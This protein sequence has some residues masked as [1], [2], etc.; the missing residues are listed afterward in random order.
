MNYWLVK[1]EPGTYSWDDFVKM[2]RDKWDGV[3]NYQARNNLKL[4]RLAD[5]VLFYHSVNDKEVVGIA[6]V[7]RE[8]YPDP[9][10]EDDRWVVVDL[11]PVRK[12]AKSVTL[13][14][15]KEDERLEGLALI[16]NSRLSV[17]PVQKDHFD[18]ILSKS[19]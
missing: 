2:G 8:Y 11:A 16:K 4:M 10:I 3:R 6:E 19:N 17:M 13:A 14:Q 1:T 18:I 5:E 9:T 7:V 12:L 15:I